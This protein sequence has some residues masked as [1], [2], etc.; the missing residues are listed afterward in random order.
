MK[1]RNSDG[2][3]VWLTRRGGRILIGDPRYYKVVRSFCTV[4]EAREWL[5]RAA[6]QGVK[7]QQQVRFVCCCSGSDWAAPNAPHTYRCGCGGEDSHREE[8]TFARLLPRR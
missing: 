3:W 7:L 4:R 5:T 6:K 2:G 1:V 8:R